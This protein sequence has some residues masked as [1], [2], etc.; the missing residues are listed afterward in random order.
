MEDT[1]RAD[2]LAKSLVDKDMISFWKSI[3][4]MNRKS[5]PLAQEINGVTGAT[6]I[7]EMWQQHYSGILNCVTNDSNKANVQ[8]ALGGISATDRLVITPLHIADA[9]RALK[10]GKSVG[11]DLLAAEHF[12]HAN[13]V[14]NVILSIIYTA[15]IT[16]G[17]VPDNIMNTI[18]VP[19]VKNKA[20]NMSEKNNYRPIALVTAASKILELVILNHIECFINTSSTQ[21]GFKRKHA[22]D[23]CIY[24]LKNTIQYYREHSSPVFTCF[25]DASRAFDRVNYWTLFKKLIQRGVPLLLVRLL[26]FWYNTQQCCIKWGNSTSVYFTTSNGVRQ[27][28]ILS[29]RLF[30]LYID[31]L[32]TL[33]HD[34][35]VGCYID[36]TCMNHYFYADDMC[37]LSPSAI[38]LQQLINVCTAYGAEHDI[39]FNPTKSKCMTILP[40]R[41]KLSIPKV[42]LNGDDLVY[43]DTIKYLGVILNN[44]F[45]DDADIMR[46]LRS[47]YASSN[48]LLRKFS[49]C[50]LPV[51]LQLVESFC[52]NFYCSPLWCDYTKQSFSKLRVAYNNIFRMLL[53]YSRRNSA[54]EM[55]VSN[56]IDGFEAHIRKSCFKFYQRVIRCDNYIVCN[57]NRNT[58]VTSNYMWRR[59]NILIYK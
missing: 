57:V 46:Q 18:I 48:I 9:I 36:S 23:L 38:G 34:L 54:S 1:A 50:S 2:A 6:N 51:K 37:L 49:H 53:G 29:P 16:H 30:S 28:G 42:S 44:T 52:L 35:K 19:L 55:F 14:L 21:F 41:Y 58:W 45:K 5:V 47:L 56:R 27:G 22:T 7:S 32:S 12:I 39:M 13:C 17:H 33:L 20:G 10:R 8:S 59:W 40:K 24:S 43:T 15:F 25:L 3:R 11:H 31:Y 4:N 26:S